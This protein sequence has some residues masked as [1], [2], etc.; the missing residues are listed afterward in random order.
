MMHKIYLTQRSI[1]ESIK[2]YNVT[3]FWLVLTATFG[4]ECLLLDSKNCY[5]VWLYGETFGDA[6][7]LAIPTIHG[8]ISTIPR[9]TFG[10][11]IVI[12]T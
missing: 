9:N 5:E 11:G 6:K 7:T 10:L 4:A 2:K 3:T 12:I 1:H 8:I